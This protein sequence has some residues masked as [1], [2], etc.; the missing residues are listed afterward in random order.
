MESHPEG[1]CLG[2]V[3]LLFVLMGIIVMVLGMTGRLPF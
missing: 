1:G 3:L 2:F